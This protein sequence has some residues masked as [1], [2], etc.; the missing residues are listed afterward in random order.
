L[1]RPSQAS[2]ATR[3]IGTSVGLAVFGTLGVT[4]AVSDWSAII[5]CVRALVRAV[6]ARQA[7]NVAGAR[8]SAVTRA[9]GH[10]GR[11][12]ATQA[13]VHGYHLAVGAG[14]ACLLAAT[15]VALFNP[16]G[17]R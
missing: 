4:A 9:V 2:R 15:A 12:P 7:Q 3:Q 13:F 17:S 6:A 1:V 11:Y 14:A 5:Y 16:T 10:A 8:I